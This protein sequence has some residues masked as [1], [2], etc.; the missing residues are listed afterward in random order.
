VA[1]K[2]AGLRANPSVQ[3]R[4][5]ELADRCNE[6]QLTRKESAQYELYITAIDLIGILQSKARSMIVGRT[7]CG[8]AT[9]HLFGMNS[10]DRIALR[11]HLIEEKGK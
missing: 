4:I 2:I 5:E 8:R 10:D 1:R 3:A 6:G 7:Q 9:V 11:E